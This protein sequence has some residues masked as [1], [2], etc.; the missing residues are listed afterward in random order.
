MATALS[1]N[2]STPGPVDFVVTDYSLLARIGMCKLESIFISIPA[3]RY[4]QSFRRMLSNIEFLLHENHVPRVI[5]FAPI[6]ADETPESA[7]R[8]FMSPDIKHT[9][10]IV[11]L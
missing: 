11:P 3:A 10:H 8:K 9:V 6:A 2:E 1:E 7:I 4:A 5:V